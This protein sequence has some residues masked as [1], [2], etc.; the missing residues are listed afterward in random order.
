MNAAGRYGSRTAYAGII[1]GAEPRGGRH[2]GIDCASGRPKMTALAALSAL[3]DLGTGIDTGV[4]ADVGALAGAT[5]IR[6]T[7]C[8]MEISGSTGR[9]PRIA[10]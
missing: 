8:I 10:A 6:P 7:Y 4:A 9:H 1:A 2:W 5:D 3:A